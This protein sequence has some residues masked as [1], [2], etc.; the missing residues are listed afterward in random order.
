MPEPAFTL[1]IEPMKGCNL[2]CRYCYSDNRGKDVLELKT[3]HAVFEKISA[4]LEQEDCREIHILWH[5]GEPLLAGLDFFKK[6]LGMAAAFF[7]R[8]HC[9]HFIQTNGLLI[10]DE[11]SHLFRDKGVEVGISLDG[12]RKIHDRMRR[13][14]DGSGSW[15]RVMEKMD[16]MEKCDLSFGICMTQTVLCRREEERIFRFFNSLGHP[17]RVNPVIPS[18][19]AGNANR[20]LLDKG[21]YGSL[22]CRF[23]DEWIS[24]PEHRI[25]ISPIDNYLGALIGE[26]ITECRHQPSCIG[27]HLGIKPDGRAVLCSPFEDMTL[28]SL[29]DST[30]QDLFDAAVCRQIKGRAEALMECR[31]CINRSICH[32]GCPFLA[33]AA[34]YTTGET[35][36]L[37]VDYKR[38]FTH[39]RRALTTPGIQGMAS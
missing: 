38:I 6:G 1:M 5:G 7:S 32:G 18:P 20:F 12:P 34:G 2:T 17:L 15:E 19:Y 21:E 26:G 4:Y 23:F 37:C 10:N 27:R 14:K 25:S 22:L 8:I 28:G 31:S 13:F 39:M 33:H 35:D 36:P 24:T 11:F 30:V 9:R 16:L 29:L 3:L